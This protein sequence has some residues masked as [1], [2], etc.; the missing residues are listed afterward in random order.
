M[1]KLNMKFEFD[2]T[3]EKKELKNLIPFLDFYVA[4]AF[5]EFAD[6]EVVKVRCSDEE[7]NSKRP[8]PDFFIEELEIAVEIKE[9]HDENDTHE[10]SSTEKVRKR[11]QNELNKLILKDEEVKGIYFLEYPWRLYIKKGKEQN[12]AKE[13]L[14]RLKEGFRTIDIENV[15]VFKVFEQKESDKERKIVLAFSHTGGFI[16]PPNIIYKNIT[17]VLK[18]ANKQLGSIE[19]RYKKR[20]L[21]IVN[22]YEWGEVEDYIEALSY[23][24]DELITNLRNIDEIWYQAEAEMEYIHKLLYRRSFFEHLTQGRHELLNNTNLFEDWF[25]ALY[26]SGDKHREKLFK[27][28]QFYCSDKEPHEIFKKESVRQTMVELGEWLLEKDRVDDA[29]WIIKK[30]IKDPDPPEPEKYRGDPK[31][32]YHEKILN[33]EDPGDIISGVLGRISWLVMKF[34][35]RKDLIVEALHYS[36]KLISHKNLFVKTQAMLPLIEIARRRNWLKEY[37]IKNNTEEYESFHSLVFEILE[38][39]SE[40]PAIAKKLLNVFAYYKDLSV[41]DALK[42]IDKLQYIPESGWLFIYFAFFRNKHFLDSKIDEIKSFNKEPFEKKLREIICT[43]NE[44]YF[45][46]KI[47]LAWNFWK[48]LRDAP[49]KFSQFKEYLFLFPRHKINS[50]II[51][52]L[53]AICS[54]ILDKYPDDSINLFKKVL[55][56]IYELPD[57]AVQ[58]VALRDVEKIISYLAENKPS[59]LKEIMKILVE[60]WMKGV[61][62]G[63][64]QNIFESYKK[65]E[66][67]ELRKELKKEFQKLYKEMKKV[68]PKLKKVSW[69]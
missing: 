23:I 30:F 56:S 58:G 22:R 4:T 1:R 42:V 28:L 48:L 32:N 57:D 41:D 20:I 15:G 35:L 36:Q 29:R 63:D 38:K 55:L 31:F 18:K 12:I 66:D 59:K 19:R 2:C 44:N 24:F 3:K 67:S 49:E 45:E 52:Y 34:A 64:I 43:D 6:K 39:Y 47:N 7:G 17:R 8:R 9:L 25:E 69:S 68:N 37:D 50:R 53:T 10:K 46:L 14:A 61:Y 5:P 21:L 16:N 26:K 51:Y 65:I 27:A 33:G 60:V 13:I 62:I 54:I 40:F 11:L